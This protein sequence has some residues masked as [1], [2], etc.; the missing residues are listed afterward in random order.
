MLGV[1]EEMMG[2]CINLWQNTFN[3]NDSAYI[4]KQFQS[5]MIVAEKPRFGLAI[6][7]CDIYCEKQEEIWVY[8]RID[9]NQKLQAVK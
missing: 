7:M 2:D 9:Y 1:T 8:L 4:T 5:F 6:S 3:R